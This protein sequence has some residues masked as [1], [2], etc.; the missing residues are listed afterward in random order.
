QAA[1]AADR[2]L[3]TQLPNAGA[4]GSVELVL[5]RIE[6]AGDRD[7]TR[8]E[9]ARD[10]EE[11][12]GCLGSVAAEDADGGLQRVLVEAAPTFGRGDRGERVDLSAVADEQMGWREPCDG[13]VASGVGL[14]ALVCEQSVDRV[15]VAAGERV[16]ELVKG[17]DEQSGA[18]R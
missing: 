2:G 9:P 8:V 14:V 4:H 13:V 12:H 1:I 11:M 7:S 5:G 18:V 15:E 10:R 3:E 16:A 6:G 17:A